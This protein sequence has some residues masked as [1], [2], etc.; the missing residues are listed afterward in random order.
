[1]PR[2]LVSGAINWDTTLFVD[3]L[4]SPGE[5][6]KVIKVVSVPGGK[7]ANAAVAAARILGKNEVGMIGMV[8]ADEIGDRQLTIL[9]E[10]GVDASCLSRHKDLPS[11]QAYVV[12]DSRGENMI[13]THRAANMAVTQESIHGKNVATTV[14]TSSMVM[15]IDPPLEVAIELA[16]LA[17]N[18]GKTLLLSP[19]MLVIHGFSALELLLRKADYLILN[20]HEAMSLA[21]VANGRTACEKLSASLGGKRVITTLG[22]DGC[23]IC[24][25]GKNMAIPAMDHSLFGLNVASTVGAGDTFEG[26]FSAFKLKRLADPEAIFLANVAAALKI[27]KEQ[28]RGSPTYEE[29]RKYANSDVLRKTYD[30]FKLT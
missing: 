26:A 16:I 11:G 29:V 13:L 9:K 23:L 2:L 21:G 30:K 27:T 18:H 12:V 1:M 15:I 14:E 8:G 7:G 19:A 5:E 4:P 28:T 3:N 22:R 20:E 10:E 24:H 6:V 17:N 25:E